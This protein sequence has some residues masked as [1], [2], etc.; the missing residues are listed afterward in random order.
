MELLTWNNS[1]YAYLLKVRHT[2]NAVIRTGGSTKPPRNSYPRSPYISLQVSHA[3]D[4]MKQNPTLASLRPTH[5][6]VQLEPVASPFAFCHSW[7]GKPGPYLLSPL[8]GF[9]H[10]SAHSCLTSAVVKPLLPKS[11][12]S[13]TVPDPKHDCP[14]FT[15]LNSLV[16]D[17]L[18]CSSESP[19]WFYEVLDSWFSC[20]FSGHL[21]RSFLSASTPPLNVCV[22]QK[23][24]LMP[25]S[26]SIVLA[27][28]FH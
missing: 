16:L 28:Q 24:H 8:L 6:S 23:F 22:A 20:W 10:P 26:H 4:E 2:H 25:P 7:A 27:E 19:P 12:V 9:R 5:I 11:P 13:S 17:T 1:S 3:A 18:N 21:A 15:Y 14:S